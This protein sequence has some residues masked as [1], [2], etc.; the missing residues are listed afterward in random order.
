MRCP[1][2][3]GCQMRR[4]RAGVDRARRTLPRSS[5][6][7]RSDVA[8]SLPP[9]QPGCASRSSVR[10][11]QRRRIGASRDEVGDVLDEVE[12]RRLGPLQ[13]V[14]D[15]DQ[16]PLRRARLEQPAERELRLRA[17]TSPSDAIS[18][19]APIASSDLD[20]RPVR[21]ALAVGEAAAAEDV[22]RVA[23]ASRKS[24]TS[25]DLPTP[26]GPSSVNSRHVR[27]ATRV[28]VRRASSRVRSRSRPTSARVERRRASGLARR[29]ARRA[30]DTPRPAA[31][32]PSRARRL[33]R[34]DATASR[35]R[36]ASRRRAAP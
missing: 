11:T 14:E 10:A 24:A 17:A 32:C 18:G 30:A 15:D 9:P 1:R 19:S 4:R 25:R 35:T 16:R 22:G 7:S 5:G 2:C 8:F 31:P 33:D 26:A 12:E 27:S 21:D 23:D 34:L 6:S 13:V 20:E 36:R 29:R 3:S 28:L